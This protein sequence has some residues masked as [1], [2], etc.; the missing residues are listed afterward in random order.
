M[1]NSLNEE[2]GL[3]QQLVEAAMNIIVE[4]GDARKVVWE[5]YKAIADGDFE[6]TDTKLAEAKTLLTKAHGM[7]TEIIQAEARGETRSPTILFVHAQDT[8]MTI[9][10]EY[11]TCREISKVAKKLQQRLTDLEN[12]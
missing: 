5:A 3:D 1:D 9:N 10:S 2:N 12:K 8:L 11:Y 4:A 7:Q 6:I